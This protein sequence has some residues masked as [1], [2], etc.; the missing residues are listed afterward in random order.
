M[1]QFGGIQY[2]AGD[3]MDFRQCQLFKDC[4]YDILWGIDEYLLG[5]LAMGARAGV[6]S[7]YNYAA[8][9]YLQMIEAFEAGDMET[10]R[11]WQAVSIRKI[12]RASWRERETLTVC[13]VHLKKS[14]NKG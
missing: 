5:A 6:G 11:K 7:T 3:L 9:V 13:I 2:T 8:P 4:S 14:R 12:G 10:A 1:P